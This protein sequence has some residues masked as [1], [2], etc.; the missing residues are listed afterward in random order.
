MT[1]NIMKFGF[2]LFSYTFLFA[3][4]YK[5]LLSLQIFN[6]VYLFWSSII[7]FGKDDICLQCSILLRIYSLYK[8]KK[9]VIYSNS[10]WV[11]QDR[12]VQIWKFE[13]S[14]YLPIAGTRKSIMSSAFV[15]KYIATATI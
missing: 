11:H 8:V 15:S 2:L 14:M 4:Y 5:E 1:G 12:I 7:T 13:V 6:L 9:K 10:T 3:N